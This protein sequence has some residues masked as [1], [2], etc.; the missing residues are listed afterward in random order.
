MKSEAIPMIVDTN[1][2]DKDSM[3][4]KADIVGKGEDSIARK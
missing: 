1:K 3:V 2:L 4:G